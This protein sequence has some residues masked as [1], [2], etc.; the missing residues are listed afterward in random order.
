[1]YE[2]KRFLG[3][4]LGIVNLAYDSDGTRYAGAQLNGYRRRQRRLRQRLQTKNT[5][6]SKRIV[7]EAERTGRGIAVEEL[8]GIRE[9]VRLRRS[10]RVTLHSWSFQTSPSTVSWAGRLSTCRTRPDPAASEARDPQ[11][12]PFAGG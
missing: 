3:V 1:M 7:A 12:C 11:A 5:S 2:P 4:D 9:R 8:T 10:Q 6:I